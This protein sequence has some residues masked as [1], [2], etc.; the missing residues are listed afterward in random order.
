VSEALTGKGVTGHVRTYP[1]VRDW[2][3]MNAHERGKVFVAQR[4]HVATAKAG[5]LLSAQTPGITGI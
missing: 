5:I 1:T 2:R 4:C 3:L